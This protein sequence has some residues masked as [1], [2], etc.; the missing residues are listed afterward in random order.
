MSKKGSVLAIDDAP[1]ILR[2]LSDILKEDYDI[3][4]SKNGENGVKLAVENLP[5]VVLLD[6]TMPNLSGFDVIKILKQNDKTKNIPVIF[7]TG[8]D[9]NNVESEGYALGAVD[10]IKKPFVT[11][12]VKHKVDFVMEFVRMRH[13]LADEGIVL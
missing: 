13:A 1:M 5:D 7:I 4:I 3:F 8:D 6:V 2:L 9:S 12:V 10:Y 11:T